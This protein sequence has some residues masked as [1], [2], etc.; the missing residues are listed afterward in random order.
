MTRMWLKRV[1]VLA[2]CIA[3]SCHWA[4]SSHWDGPEEIANVDF[5]QIYFGVRSS[6]DHHDPYDGESPL[7]AFD[8]SGL[9]FPTKPP[10]DPKTDRA[11]MAQ[12]MYLPSGFLV[13][14]PF[15]LAPWAVAQAVW[16]WLITGLLVVAGLLMWD[17]AGDAPVLAGCLAGFMLLNSVMVLILGNPAGVVA[18]LCVIAAWCFWKERFG[19]LGVALLA[20][21]LA[22]KPQDAGFVWLYFVLAGGAG[23]KRAWQTLAVT[24]VLGLCSVIWIA[25]VSPHWIAELGRNIRVEMAPGG[26]N[27]PDPF[28][29]LGTGFDPVI[30]MQNT[31]RVFRDDASFYRAASFGLIGIFVLAWGAA[32]A[33]KRVQG[34]GAL[35]ALAATSAL[36]MLPSYHRDHDAKLLM[37]MIPACAMLW[38]GGGARRW[39]ALGM[40]WA[41][42][43]VTSDMPVIGLIVAGGILRPSRVALGGKLMLAALQPQAV[44][45]LAAGCFYLWAFWRYEE[46]ERAV[47]ALPQGEMEC[48]A[49]I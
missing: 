21:S 11:V 19:F 35:L 29:A 12:A 23:R 24:A 13:L 20:V 40:T 38:A 39:W 30:S 32:V 4:L 22:I 41:A 15:A 43:A 47:G 14:A 7:R 9:R 49:Q 6:L 8:A 36:T 28:G 18:P 45:L 46:P 5:A 33:R 27:N 25:P 44:V 3:F 2:L 1:V 31:F 37:L 16:F 10:A 48:T 26:V 42:I 17:L 34:R